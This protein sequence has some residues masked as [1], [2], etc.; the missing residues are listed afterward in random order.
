[1]PEVNKEQLRIKIVED[2][3]TIANPS[4]LIYKIYKIDQIEYTY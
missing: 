3:S 1:M 2:F 4:C